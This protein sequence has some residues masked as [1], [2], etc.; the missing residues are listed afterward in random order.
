MNHMH[1]KKRGCITCPKRGCLNAA[2]EAALGWPLI[3]I[4]G[5]KGVFKFS[6][7]GSATW[8]HCIDFNEWRV[9]TT[10]AI[11]TQEPQRRAVKVACIW[12]SA[13]PGCLG[14]MLISTDQ[15]LPV[16]QRLSLGVKVWGCTVGYTVLHSIGDPSRNKSIASRQEGICL[17]ETGEPVSLLRHCLSVKHNLTHSDLL[18]R[19]LEAKGFQCFLFLVHLYFRNTISVIA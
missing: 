4:A 6:T 1:P 19:P 10:E 7:P 15:A 2:P 12:R 17:R 8:F 13:R 5:E 3:E 14:L 16:Q 18:R 9:H 11:I